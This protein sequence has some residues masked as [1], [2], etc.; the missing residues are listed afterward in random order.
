MKNS[1]TKFGVYAFLLALLLFFFALYFGQGLS[2]SSQEV[3]GYASMIVS[4][5]FVYF[6][7]KHFRDQQNNGLVTFWKGFIIGI[8]IT[9][10]AALAFAIVDYIYVTQINPDFSAQYLEYTLAEMKATMSPEAFAV[11]KAK[12]EAQM[13]A[14]SN[15]I[16]LGF[17][18]FLTV[19][20]LGI[21]IS[22][23]SSLIL[24]RKN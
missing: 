3:I 17:I 16:F 23:I 9:C 4:L 24:Q 19:L 12:V 18:M 5:S 11:K 14:F 7:I 10:F 15:P 21:I 6:G 1:I 22:L 20:I 13:E 2:F 8:G